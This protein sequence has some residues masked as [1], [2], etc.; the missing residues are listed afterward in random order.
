MLVGEVGDILHQIRLVDTVWDLR[1][2]DLVVR[3]ARLDLSLGT[4]HDTSTTSLVGILHALQTVDIRSRG[5]VRT[6]DILHQT[7]CVDIRIVDIRTTAV[8]HFTEVMRR[9]V[10][11]HTH[12][13]TVTAV[14]QQVRDLRR[15][16]RGLHQR[17]VEVVHH[18]DR[19]FLQ[20]VHDML[21]HLREAALCITHG[22]G[23]VA[24]HT[25]EVT[26]SV[27]QCIAQVP[28]LCHAHQ[29]SVHGGV[30]M[31]VVFT[32][33]LTDD[34]R[35]FLIRLCRYVI[36]IHHTIQDTA[37]YWLK[38]VTHIRE[39]TCHDD[40]HRVVDVRGLHLLLDVDFQNSVVVDCL[41]HYCFN[42]SNFPVFRV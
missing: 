22:C 29:C 38:A 34:A 17:V 37:M 4:H 24:V 31:G 28:V 8:D 25:T 41:I 5:E 15:H 12:C 10:R 2:D 26:L 18:V 33:H 23:R 13:D 42:Y 3:L 9:H 32:E 20:V 21:T 14:H 11:R 6:G 27:H 36:D 40:R 7:L 1:H 19:V 35:A 16:H 30:A 39:G